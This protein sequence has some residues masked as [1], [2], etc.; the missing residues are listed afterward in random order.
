MVTDKQTRRAWVQAYR[1]LKH[2]HAK[3]QCGRG[4]LSEFPND[5]QDFANM[6]MQMQEKRH[7][8]DYDP[9]GVYYKSAVTADIDAAEEAMKAFRAVPN[10]HRKAF[11]I[12][13]ALEGPRR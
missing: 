4:Q 3:N 11:A 13:V 10:R 9:T 2:G 12:L 1:C 5:I 6:F 8:A 7:R